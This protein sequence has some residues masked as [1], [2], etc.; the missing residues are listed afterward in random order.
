MKR[1]Q[2]SLSKKPLKF[3]VLLQRLFHI[4]PYWNSNFQHKLSK[5]EVDF[6]TK[7][8]RENFRT[9]Q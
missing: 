8:G 4:R 9:S 7:F 2:M 3:L 5:S 1:I 6:R